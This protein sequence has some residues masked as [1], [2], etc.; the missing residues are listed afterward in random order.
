MS[1]GERFLVPRKISRGEGKKIESMA[2]H[3]GRRKRERVKVV[4]ENIVV[5]PSGEVSK[6]KP[7]DDKKTIVIFQWPLGSGRK[8]Y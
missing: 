6:E 7:A 8:R 3:I 4:E 1:R 2:A 5:N